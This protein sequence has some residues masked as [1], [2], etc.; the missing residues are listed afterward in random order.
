MQV[1]LLERIEK[2]G[3]IGDIVNV[4]PG[5]ARNF[6]LPKQKAL[7]A[8]AE[9]MVRFETERAQIEA[10]NLEWQKEAES[11]SEKL[12]GAS[13]IL[14][15][16]AGDSGQ[17]YG[18]ASARDIAEVATEDGYSVDKN[19]IILNTPIKAIGLHE[20]MVRLHPDVTCNITVNVARTPDEAVL[21]A[22][23]EDVLAQDTDDD[24]IDA[25]AFFEEEATPD[26]D[27]D[28]DADGDATDDANASEE[29]TN[30]DAEEE[31][32]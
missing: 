11:V 9:N 17:L 22:K 31:T 25:E 18:S 6:L 20:V 16:Q 10:R 14:I 3:Q 7:R 5:Y 4:K 26:L 15:R 29:A 27:D 1:V 30:D 8:T 12:A 2:L 28:A 32:T 23:G 24:D 19:Q 21:Q 13:F